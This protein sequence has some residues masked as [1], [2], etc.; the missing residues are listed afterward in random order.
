MHPLRSSS[1][2]S[3]AFGAAAEASRPRERRKQNGSRDHARRR[4]PNVFVWCAARSPAASLDA[5]AIHRLWTERRSW[6]LHHPPA[7]FHFEYA[8]PSSTSSLDASANG[9]VDFHGDIKTDSEG[10]TTIST[11]AGVTVSGGAGIYRGSVSFDQRGVTGMSFG[12]GIP[13]TPK[14]TVKASAGV[15][16]TYTVFAK[17]L[18]G[19]SQGG[20]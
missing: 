5:R 15:G 1:R 17:S 11:S 19:G 13:T 16:V 8:S 12:V 7:Q 9:F 6:T 2:C 20:K 14:L 18:A 3:F 10:T 4:G